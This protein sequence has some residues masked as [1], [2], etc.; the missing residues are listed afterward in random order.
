MSCRQ[1]LDDHIAA[2]IAAAKRD[3]ARLDAII[4]ELEEAMPWGY[5]CPSC[6]SAEYRDLCDRQERR[7]PWLAVMLR[8]RGRCG[9]LELAA[10]I[11]EERWP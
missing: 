7:L 5:C 10:K 1:T 4:G 3:D 9:D 2:T 6:A 11:D 8:K